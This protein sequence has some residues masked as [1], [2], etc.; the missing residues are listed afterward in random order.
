MAIRTGGF[1]YITWLHKYWHS[2]FPPYR[3]GNWGNQNNCGDS[4]SL[5]AR[6]SVFPLIKF[7]SKTVYFV[8]QPLL[9]LPLKLKFVTWRIYDLDVARREMVMAVGRTVAT[10]K[11]MCHSLVI[12]RIFSRFSFAYFCSA[13]S[14]WKEDID[15]GGCPART[16]FFSKVNRIKVAI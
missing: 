5:E 1:D 14:V 12:V 13:S 15:G 4:H 16:V 8:S 3:N 2:F 10:C 7:V 6:T 11:R 9:L